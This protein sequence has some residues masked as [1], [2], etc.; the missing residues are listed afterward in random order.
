[1]WVVLDGKA[2]KVYRSEYHDSPL[3]KGYVPL[4]AVDVWEHAYYLDYQDDRQK[5]VEA[6]LDNLL[7]L[8]YAQVRLAAAAK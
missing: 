1:M 4:L 2:V 6:V 5:Y 3:L 7:N 8:D